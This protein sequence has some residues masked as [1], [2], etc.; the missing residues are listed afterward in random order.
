MPRLIAFKDAMRFWLIFLA[1]IGAAVC[2]VAIVA[3]LLFGAVEFLL[4]IPVWAAVIIVLMV[5]S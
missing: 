4:S 2:A 5:L 1:V 3:A